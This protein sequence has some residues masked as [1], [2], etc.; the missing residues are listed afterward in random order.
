MLRQSIDASSQNRI[1]SPVEGGG[2]AFTNSYRLAPGASTEEQAIGGPNPIPELARLTRRGDASRAWHS[3]DGTTWEEVGSQVVFA[4][5]ADPVR[6]GIPLANR[7]TSSLGWVDVEWFRVRRLVTPVP[8][9][10]L[11]PEEPGPFSG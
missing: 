8:S 2:V 11:Q 5:L 1:A 6:V 10:S 4:G 9:V 7:V 3:A